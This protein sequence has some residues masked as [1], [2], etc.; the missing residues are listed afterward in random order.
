MK[1]NAGSCPP[2]EEL[3]AHLHGEGTKETEAHLSGCGSCRSR[4]RGLGALDD[5]L[6]GLP[7]AGAAPSGSCPGEEALRRFLSGG[8]PS[9]EAHLS[10]CPACLER[11]VSIADVASS[12]AVPLPG[13]LRTR[14]EGL[15]QRRSVR[16]TRRRR[17]PLLRR[18]PGERP[19]AAWFAAAAAA[20]VLLA[21]AGVYGRRSPSPPPSRETARGETP[22]AP[23]PEVPEGRPE[24]PESPAS[25]RDERERLE[26]AL[27]ELA[28]TRR[29]YLEEARA[30]DLRRL[31]EEQREAEARLDRLR[32][33]EIRAAEER[34]RRESSPA[35]T[36]AAVAVLERAEGE[37]FLLDRSGRRPAAAGL[38]IL[39][40]QGLT[41]IGAASE[42]A[43]AYPDGTR[44]ELGGDAVMTLRSEGA[45]ERR[46]GVFLARGL[47]RADVARQ[48]GGAPM[49]F[50]T[51][52]GEATVLGTVLRL[53]VEE[54]RTRLEVMEGKV[55]LKNLAG[56][57]VDVPAGHQAVAAS[58]VELAA[59]P[60]DDPA[61]QAVIG[62]VLIN[63]D[64][65]LP[66]PGY[67]P[68]PQGAVLELPRLPRRLN[69][70][71]DTR[72]ERVGSVLFAFDDNPRFQLQNGLPYSA[73]GGAS[74]RWWAWENPKPGPHVLTATPFTGAKATGAAGRPLTLRFF[75]KK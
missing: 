25:R 27:E 2:P 51:P 13:D 57:T 36:A 73:F 45:G 29:R 39:E 8:E 4:L 44:L 40:G 70:R 64:N 9:L 62:F 18:I 53:A 12:P 67:E 63:A 69:M 34:A 5:L 21:L 26:R 72:P 7:P 20:L 54:R 58:G 32:R 15:F 17:F 37:V 55:R 22:P 41:A 71:A 48:P 49:V 75:V 68:I 74:G 46:K 28:E 30:H 47:L 56:K 24:V 33:E 6:G 19:A 1:G 59:R 43:L 35:T 52:H 42:L 10:D 61:V 11:L 50:R 3:L 23:V 60:I 66:V 31:E 14:L 65:G 38:P 16:P